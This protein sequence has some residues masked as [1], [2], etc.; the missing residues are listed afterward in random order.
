MA[1]ET[2]PAIL[3]ERLPDT[4]RQGVLAAR[5]SDAAPAT[6][7]PGFSLDQ[8][9]EA[10]EAALVRRALAQAGGDRGSACQLLGISARSLRYLIQKH[11]LTAAD[12]AKN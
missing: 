2:T 9:L 5:L 11:N 10:L 3:P 12:G 1:L 6:L 7:A 8:H 4:V